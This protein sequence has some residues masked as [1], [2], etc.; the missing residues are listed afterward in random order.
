ME[1]EKH[2]LIQGPNHILEWKSLIVRPG[3]GLQLM[4]GFLPMAT[5]RIG[6]L[7]LATA[8]GG[9][10]PSL[11]EI[12]LHGLRDAASAAAGGPCFEEFVFC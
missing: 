11:L 10:I 12:H 4:G 8:F 3:R 1:G 7:T 9:F 2:K 6:S 5:A